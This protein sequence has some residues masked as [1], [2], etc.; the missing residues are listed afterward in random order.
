MAPALP[1]AFALVLGMGTAFLERPWILLP[2]F[3]LLFWQERPRALLLLIVSVASYFF[4][5]FHLPPT[6]EAKTGYFRPKLMKAGRSP[7]GMYALA[8]GSLTTEEGSFPCSIYLPYNGRKI[9]MNQDYIVEGEQKI[10]DRFQSNFK[11]KKW[12]AVPGTFRM[13][14]KRFLAKKWVRAYLRKKIRDK[15]AFQLVA[16]LATGELMEKSLAYD[17]GRLGL[18]HLLAISGFHFSLLALFIGKIF[19]RL[20]PK[21][22]A[23]SFL[24]MLL[25]LFYLYM[26]PTA[27]VMRAGITILLPMIGQFFD[28]KMPPL[29]ALA[30]AAIIALLLHPL[31]LTNLGFQLSYLA[32]YGILALYEPLCKLVGHV[33]HI[34]TKEEALALS[35]ADKHG[36]LLVTFFRLAITLTLSATLI[37]LPLT[38]LVFG[39][40][41]LL[42]LFYN[43]FFPL[44]VALL[45]FLLLSSFLCPF[46]FPLV[47]FV[48]KNLLVFTQHPPKK[49]DFTLHT[50][51]LTLEVVILLLTLFTLVRVDFIGSFRRKWGLWR[52]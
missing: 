39:K 46:L 41:P 50:P 36:Y 24:L 42:S 51:F 43:F 10:R 22:I 38:L 45:L 14:E 52:P 1:Y 34:R 47:E 33:L 23:G 6:V 44:G 27:S 17:F 18:M 16:A 20:L 40:F 7:F 28:L 4:A 49:L 37:T 8:A 12:R 3:I 5:V 32:T 48:A 21:K 13:A 29:N 35:L 2:A 26:G 11:V 9:L 19:I 15:Q 31:A 30:L 25:C